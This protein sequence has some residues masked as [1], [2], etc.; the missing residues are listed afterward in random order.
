MIHDNEIYLSTKRGHKG[1]GV[2]NIMETI[3][4]YVEIKHVLKNALTERI[5]DRDVFM[6]GIDNSYHY[7]GYIIYKTKDLVS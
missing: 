4:K 5:Y 7:E 2:H 3:E 6:K 1:Y